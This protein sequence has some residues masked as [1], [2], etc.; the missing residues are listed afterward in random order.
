MAIAYDLLRCP[1]Q[2][3]IVG[4]VSSKA[5]FAAGDLDPSRCHGVGQRWSRDTSWKEGAVIL[6][7]MVSSQWTQGR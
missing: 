5:L 7:Q 1:L 3:Q 2:N 4:N 6:L